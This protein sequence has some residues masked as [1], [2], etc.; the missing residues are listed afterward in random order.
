[1][2]SP[3]L[4]DVLRF[5]DRESD[6]YTAE[7]VLKTLGAEVLGKGTT[8]AGAAIVRSTLAEAGIPLGGVRIVELPFEPTPLVHALW[9]HP[10]HARDPEHAWMVELFQEAGRIVESGAHADD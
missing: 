2:K 4:A 5:M 8:A 7:L 3:P 6:N 1:V 10:V 9:W